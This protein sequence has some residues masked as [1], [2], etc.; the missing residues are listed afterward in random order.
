LAT[1]REV[2][3]AFHQVDYVR[4]LAFGIVVGA[5]AGV[6]A[7]LFY[8]GVEAGKLFFLNQLAGLSLPHPAGEQLF[9]AEPGAYRPWL[10]PVFT[11]SLGLLTGFL[12]KRF[13][14]ESIHGGTDGTDSMIK[15]FHRQAGVIKPRV[16]LIK[17]TTSILTIATGCSAG[18]E[19]P[20]SQ[21]GAGVGSYIADKLKLTARERRILLLTGAAGGLGAIFRAP[22]GGALTAI[23]VIYREDFEAE[24]ILSAVTSSVVAYTIFTLFY[25]AEPIFGIPRFHF[26]D[27]RELVFYAALAVACSA[28]GWLYVRTFYFL[29]YSVFRRIQDHVGIMWTTC[30]G[31]LLM[32]LFGIFFPQTLTGGYGYLE[33]AILG[34]IPAMMMLAIV[35]GKIVATSLTIGSGMSGGMFAPALFVG[36]MTGGV[37]GQLANKYWPTI[38]SEPGGY[39]LVGMAAFFAG[40]ANAPIGPLIMVTEITQGYGLLAPLMLASALCLV[41]SRKV[42]LYEHQ[43]DNKFQSPAHEHS[44]TV[45]VLEKLTVRDFFKPGR[46]TVL[47]RGTTLKALTNIIAGTNE[48]NFPVRDEQGRITGMISVQDVRKVLFEQCLFELIVV[49]D[50]ASPVT[51]LHP[52]DDLY[53]ALLTFLS[54]DYSQLPVFEEGD[55]RIVL[56]LINREDVMRAYSQTIKKIHADNV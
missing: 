42:S 30:L 36:G 19:G 48:T 15:S 39:V 7:V 40:V 49:G 47:E 1:W 17:G 21:I 46:V 8:L 18:Q 25:G 53:Q 33:M 37:V 2:V 51:F 54:S 9:H 41:M 11:A 38:A 10:V 56:G 35:L 34:Q 23:E 4:G 20:I 50:L 32:G 22:L 5:F 43:V 28:S 52:D 31:G 27:A 29:K 6:A 3:R 26:H 24:A 16:P 13:I 55:D 14:P 12:V 45:N 44:L